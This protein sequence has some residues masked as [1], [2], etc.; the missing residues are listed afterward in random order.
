MVVPLV[1]ALSSCDWQPKDSVLVSLESEYE[2]A[3]ASL[4]NTEVE[5]GIHQ[6]LKWVD[7]NTWQTTVGLPAGTYQFIARSTDGRYI[8]ETL[9][10]RPEVRRYRLSPSKRN[11]EA[12]QT[13]H[14]RQGLGPLLTF[15][16]AGTLR[17][18]NGRQAFVVTHG[19]RS[20]MI[21]GNIANDRLQV[22]LPQKGFF[23]LMLLIPGN[24]PMEALFPFEL[25]DADK[26]YGIVDLNPSPSQAP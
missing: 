21:R 12:G 9:E 3:R 22:R 1:L 26:D 2:F 4:S 25:L 19:E 20:T 24:P 11:P 14:S 17:N 18:L 10:Y 13:A 6:P 8:Q 23:R 5:P 15:R 16:V 7:D